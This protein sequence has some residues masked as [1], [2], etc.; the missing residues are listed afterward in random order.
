MN[1]SN[2][3]YNNSPI[4]NCGDKLI[5]LVNSNTNRFRDQFENFLHQ[6]VSQQTT[7]LSPSP[8]TG[9]DD[10]EYNDELFVFYM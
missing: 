8:T 6:K 9:E 7:T 5:D 4:N 2:D 3:I 1:S 10:L